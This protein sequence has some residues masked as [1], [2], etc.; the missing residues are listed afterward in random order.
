MSLTYTTAMTELQA[1]VQQIQDA[2]VPIDELPE[3][4]KRAG[5]LLEFCQTKLRDT[6][7]E[8]EKLLRD[9]PI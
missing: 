8:L 9:E 1:I 5:E 6:E 7:S 3:R 2:E 4:V